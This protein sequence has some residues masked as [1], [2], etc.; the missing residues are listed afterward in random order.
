MTAARIIAGVAAVVAGFVLLAAATPP[1]AGMWSLV[2]LGC[3]V[4]GSGVA[5]WG[6]LD[7]LGVE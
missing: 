5:A 7:A 1:A 3:I 6:A 4:A 2:A